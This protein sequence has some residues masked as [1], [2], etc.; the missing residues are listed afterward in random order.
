MI[1]FYSYK[2]AARITM[3]RE[4]EIHREQNTKWKKEKQ[5]PTWNNTE[6]QRKTQTNWMQ[7][8]KRERTKTKFVLW[9]WNI[10]TDYVSQTMV[11]SDWANIQ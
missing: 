1:W 5:G 2:I 9:N 6:T 7:K 8:Q 4:H 3:Y 11:T 10:F